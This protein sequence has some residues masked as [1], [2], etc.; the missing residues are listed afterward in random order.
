MIPKIKVL[1]VEDD[2]DWQEIIQEGISPLGYQLDFASTSKEA[3][4]R[5][6]H[7]TYHVALLDKRLDESDPENDEGL[8]IATTIAGLGE[9]TKIIVYT[10]YGNIDDAREAFRNIKVRDFIG[11]DKPVSEILKAIEESAEEAVLEFRRPARISELLLVEEEAT[12]QFLSGFPSKPGLGSNTQD[13]ELFSKR[14]LAEYRP[15]LRDRNE[16]KIL[17][18]SNIP[19]LQ[20]RFWSKMLAFP[21]AV[22]IGKFSEMKTILQTID[23]DEA[24]RLS[25][26]INNKID[27][28]FDNNS[29]PLFGG[30]IFELNNT[31]LNEFVS[32]Y[33][34]GPYS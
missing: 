14:L 4:D 13:L 19:T 1:Y 11:K 27:E 5:L 3:T 2:K 21:I 32:K 20:V 34:F 29:F 17:G 25:L 10:A 12:K 15:L 26:N 24:L 9:G 31:S 16:A 18:L 6:K 28:L 7:S 33:E 22:W 23:S 30:T 8:S